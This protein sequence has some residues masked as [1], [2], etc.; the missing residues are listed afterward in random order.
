MC[1][2]VYVYMCGDVYAIK[3]ECSLEGTDSGY[4]LVREQSDAL[5]NLHNEADL[6]LRVA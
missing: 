2:C 1:I 4:L 5:Q 3:S 6:G